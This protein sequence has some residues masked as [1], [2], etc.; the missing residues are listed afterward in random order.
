MSKCS[1][2]DKCVN[3]PYYNTPYCAVHVSWHYT[4]VCRNPD[5]RDGCDCGGYQ[6]PEPYRRD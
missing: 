3:P 4:A 1:H 6:A 2:D 5:H